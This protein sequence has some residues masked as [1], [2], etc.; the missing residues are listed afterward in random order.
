MIYRDVLGQIQ[1][2]EISTTDRLI[3]TAIAAERGVSR[4]PVRD[5]LMRLE[6]EGYLSATTRGFML[7]N[8]SHSEILDVFEIRRLL[9]P[10]AAAWAAQELDQDT[11][12][13]M[14]KAVV[15]AESTLETGDISLF[16][17]ASEVFRSGWLSAVPNL[18][19][20][21][22][23][24]RYLIQVQAVRIATM[25]DRG[26]HEV[27]VAGQKALLDAFKRRD[28]VA[29][30]DQMLRFVVAGE[31]SFNELSLRDET[32]NGQ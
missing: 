29:A 32:G 13:R 17:R 26:A 23:I 11:L 10:R 16:Y 4:M 9:E 20:Q 2:G 3:D 24:R 6:H 19:L 12:D 27:I 15:E 8:L 18:H 22:T 14:E 7:P 25:G 28:S 5:A 1:R 21:N 30:A 31:T